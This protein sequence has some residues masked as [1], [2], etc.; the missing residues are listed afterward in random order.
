M[1][2]IVTSAPVRKLGAE[3]TAASSV[4]HSPF[5]IALRNNYDELY[6]DSSVQ[7]KRL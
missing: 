7:A 4:Q 1:E 6:N 5:N 3:G 2:V